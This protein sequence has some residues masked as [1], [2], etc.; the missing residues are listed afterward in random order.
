MKR[1]IL[2]L[3]LIVVLVVANISPLC[4]AES[5]LPGE[6]AYLESVIPSYFSAAGISISDNLQ[7]TQGYPIEGNPN[8]SM[9]FL[10]DG[11]LLLGRFVVET[12]VGGYSSSFVADSNSAINAL[13]RDSYRRY[14]DNTRL[15]Q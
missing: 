4:L 8:S 3:F 12:S 2:I 11:N 1:R 5:Y 15:G 9:Y 7:L 14:I 10:F 6:I 13:S